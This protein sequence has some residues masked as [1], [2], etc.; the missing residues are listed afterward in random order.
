[1]SVENIWGWHMAEEIDV[2]KFQIGYIS[3]RSGFA[4]DPDSNKLVIFSRPHETRA[5]RQSVF[6]INDMRSVDSVVIEPKVF[7]ASS[8]GG[9]SSAIGQSMGI[10]MANKREREK[11]A[12]GT[13]ILINIRSIDTPSHFVNIFDD[14][15]REKVLEALTQ[16]CETGSVNGRF[17][18]IEPANEAE[19]PGSQRNSHKKN[20]GTVASEKKGFDRSIILWIF[21]IIFIIMVLMSLV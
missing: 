11:A 12:L 1:M 5:W 2:S 13:G 15:E 7:Y 3:A 21:F 9:L 17:N 4:V 14:G 10:A 20:S 19:K 16:I 6:D 18:N 8:G